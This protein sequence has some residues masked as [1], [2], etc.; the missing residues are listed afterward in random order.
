MTDKLLNSN[1]ICEACGGKVDNIDSMKGHSLD[2]LTERH[3]A[4]CPGVF[5]GSR[6]RKEQDDAN[7]G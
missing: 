5:R 3:A 6:K 2:K 7:Q 1:K 4:T